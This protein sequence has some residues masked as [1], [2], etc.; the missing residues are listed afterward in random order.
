MKAALQFSAL[1]SALL[2]LLA[3]S[4]TARPDL[5]QLYRYH[6][7]AEQPQLPLIIIPG[8]SGSRLRD[9][10]SGEELWPGNWWRILSSDYR[11]LALDID[12]HTLEPVAD[13]YQAVGLTETALG[14][15][16]YRPL[17]DTL[18][19]AGGFTRRRPGQPLS[20]PGRH[21]YVLAYDWRQDNVQAAR[22]LDALIAQIRRDYGQP[23]LK[24]NIIAHSMGGLITRYFLRYGS[25]DVLD[26]NDFPV[27]LAGAQKV[28][29][30]ILLGTP[31]LGAVQTLH[32]FLNGRR[33]VRTI[34]NEVLATMPSTFQLFP[35]PISP[36]LITRD[37]EPLA[38]DL[39]DVEIW[40]RFQWS[41]FDPKVI[42][43]IQRH[44]PDPDY[45]QTLHRWFEK[46]LERA[47]RFVWSLTV[48]LPQ[49][50]IKL[51]VF[52]GDC[53]MTP[54]RVLVEE[55]AGESVIR[56]RPTD[57]AAPLAG[58]DYSRAMLEPG[59]GAV[60]KPSLLA[61]NA[62]DPT[63]PRHRYSFF[64]LAYSFFLC[65]KHDRLTS[66]I[67]FQ[68]NLLNVLLGGE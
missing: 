56:L 8:L 58:V 4:G 28:N 13:N 47:R 57:I 63:V 38:R 29:K 15:D 12:P 67:N 27:S 50:P 25:A 2:L 5:Q 22:A 66:N 21:Y 18:E 68:D 1:V 11:H 39:F 51:I 44:H 3:C 16:Y 19:Q 33:V 20:R 42:A 60:T 37:G 43:R 48:P 14:R 7:S 30:V 24:V 45:L 49:T 40:R 17:I 61:R 31:N 54:A 55:V 6:A 65:E 41:V 52:G 59:D 9:R 23:E 35:H 34:P 53:T 46:R 26:D 32:G 64:P 10:L 36:W 62:L